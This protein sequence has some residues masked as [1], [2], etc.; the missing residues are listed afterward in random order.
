MTT[1]ATLS[2]AGA[3]HPC[4]TP[5]R[6]TPATLC[7]KTPASTPLRHWHAQAHAILYGYMSDTS[8]STISYHTQRTFNLSE[9]PSIHSFLQMPGLIV[10]AN[11]RLVFVRSKRPP[12]QPSGGHSRSTPPRLGWKHR[13]GRKPRRGCT[14]CGLASR[15][16][17]Q[18]SLINLVTTGGISW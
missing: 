13:L 5:L 18:I 11:G 10:G 17:V 4:D 9:T 2:G 12:P 3:T 14:W 15:H 1:C 7:G 8:T 16:N 6:H